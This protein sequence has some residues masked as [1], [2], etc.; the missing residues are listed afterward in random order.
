MKTENSSFRDRDGF[1]FY[2][3]AEVFRFIKPTYLSTFNEM[4]NNGFLSKLIEKK[5]LVNYEE[6]AE[7]FNFTE[8]KVIKQEKINFISYPYEW[9]FYQLKKA[10]LLTLKI[11]LFCLENGYSL[12][13]AS[14]FNIQFK[15]TNPIFI[16]T[17]S[18][19]KYVE[20]KPWSAYRQFCQHFFAPLVLQSYGI[21]KLNKYLI[22]NI[23]GVPLDLCASIL[24][25][26]SKLNLSVYL[27]IHLNSK[28]EKKH[29]EDLSFK[30]KK[31]AVNKSKLIS[32][33]KYLIYNTEKLK[34]PKNKTNW[35]DYYKEFTYNEA[36]FRE[37]KIFIEKNTALIKP[38]FTIDCGSNTGVFSEI[39]SIYSSNVLSFDFDSSVIHQQCK[40]FSSKKIS[41]V[42]PLVQDLCQPSPSI[43][44]W[45]KERKSFLERLP[46][47][48]CTLALALIHHLVL[49][50]NLTFNMVAELFASFSKNLLIEFVTKEDPQSQRLLVSKKD[51]FDDYTQFNFEKSFSEHFKLVEKSELTDSTRVM[52]FYTKK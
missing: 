40:V 16:D 6:S 37:K 32:I 15:G 51:I 50:N 19:E 45:N 2:S 30:N 34:L 31:I 20:G 27:H 23:E 26:Y 47:N 28:F 9:S 10:A 17:L 39:A 5:Y 49:S 25:F 4:V 46:E 14:S 22:E 12:K 7:E 43:G 11:Q 21:D 52:F 35:T 24:P 38:E 42:L 36:N 29:K 48:S 13:D 18:F 8:G 33:I 1:V 44:W 41:N 3:N